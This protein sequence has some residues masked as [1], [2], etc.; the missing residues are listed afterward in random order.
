MPDTHAPTQSVPEPPIPP[1]PITVSLDGNFAMIQGE[2]V[3]LPPVQA[4]VLSVLADAHPA[5][6][7]I[8]AM[9]AA[10]YGA[11]PPTSGVLRVHIHCLRRVLAGKGVGIVTVWGRGWRLVAGV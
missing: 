5:T 9:L 11:L 10:V 8:D 2:I 7:S 6:V 3:R 4:E 1:A